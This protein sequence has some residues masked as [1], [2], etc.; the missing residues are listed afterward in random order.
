MASIIPS[1]VAG[2]AQGWFTGMDW[3]NAQED[4]KL[5]RERM[6]AEDI[7]SGKA[8]VREGI[9]HRQR[10]E[11]LRRQ[12]E[13]YDRQQTQ[14]APLALEDYSKLGP[15]SRERFLR[16]GLL[17]PMTNDEYIARLQSLAIPKQREIP[18][19]E[20]PMPEQPTPAPQTL[21]PKP[22]APGMPPIMPGGNIVTG[23]DIMAMSLPK[24]PAE[25]PFAGAP[26]SGTPLPPPRNL[27]P[28]VETTPGWVPQTAQEEQFEVTEGRRAAELA[29][30]KAT[31]ARQI[32][33]AIT[34]G[35]MTPEVGAT[36]WQLL[37]PD[38]PVPQEIAAATLA[39]RPRA[40]IAGIEARTEGTQASTGLTQARTGLTAAQTKKVYEVD[41]PLGKAKITLTEEQTR[42]AIANRER[43]AEKVKLAWANTGIKRE[44]LAAK[45]R[46][47]GAKRAASEVKRAVTSDANILKAMATDINVL[48]KASGAFSS[49]ASDEAKEVA[50]GHLSMLYDQLSHK[51][52]I[53]DAVRANP[54]LA[55]LVAAARKRF[56]DE[57]IAQTPEIRQAILRL[58]AKRGW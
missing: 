27:P 24:P 15:T 40:E 49:G 54:T 1:L 34:T 53:D 41:I 6:R 44:E 19:R 30:R 9:E 57:Q 18:R 26:A 17:D 39:P 4:R 48:G 20:F 12:Q 10:M 52:K 29:T 38:E 46:D 32:S 16:E 43:D 22:E 51:A 11:N 21:A 8:D 23:E 35:K 28:R 5:Q 37:F 33:E 31:V 7:R 58:R 45:L 42:N 13:L 50:R 14:A 47:A 2:A 55:P 25:P 3:L 36:N 56:T